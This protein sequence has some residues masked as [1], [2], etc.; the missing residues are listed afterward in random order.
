MI[1][2][3][4]LK[5]DVNSLYTRKALVWEPVA[6]CNIQRRLLFLIE[7]MKSHPDEWKL[8]NEAAL[9]RVINRPNLIIYENMIEEKE[10]ILSQVSEYILSPENKIAYSGYNT[11][12]RDDF[13]YY[14]SNLYEFLLAVVRSGD[15]SLIIKYIGEIAL[16]RFEKGFK[17]DEICNLFTV[18]DDIILTVLIYKKAPAEPQAG[19]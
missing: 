19:N 14:L 9:K 8:R 4:D 17:P 6:R 5:L 12:K 3:I 13:E 10:N 2:Y 15:R 1:K 11:M 16:K 7:K 18:F